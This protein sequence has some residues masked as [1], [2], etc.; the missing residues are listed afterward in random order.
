MQLNERTIDQFNRQFLLTGA[1]SSLNWD[2]LL[3]RDPSNSFGLTIIRGDV[4]AN[5]VVTAT[6]IHN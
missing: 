2:E 1:P 3:Q 4:I 6:R 5:P